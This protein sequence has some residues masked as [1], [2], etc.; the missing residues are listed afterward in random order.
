[1]SKFNFEKYKRGI[2]TIEVQTMTPEKFINLLWKN[3]V[4]IS[5][6]RRIDITTL[7]LD[8]NLRYYET[9]NSIAKRTNTKLKIIKRRGL[10]FFIIKNRRRKTL[11]L[12]ILIFISIIYYLST[13]I[14]NINITTE[15]NVTPYEIRNQLKDL[16]IAPALRKKK[17]NVYDLEEKLIKNNSDIMWVKA[18]IEGVKLNISI[19]ERQ[20]P[21]NVISD[22]S[23]CHIV[24]K[25]D[26]EIIRVYSSA[27]TAI[28]K[29][30]DIV[31][32]GDILVKGEQGKEEATYPV[33]ASAEVIARTFYEEKKQVPIEYVS[34]DRTGKEDK[35]VYIELFG[36]KIY[37]KKAKN[38]F[39]MYDKISIDDSF[40][41][42]EVYFEVQEK[43]KK[44]NTEEVK[45]KIADELF[46]NI[47]AKLDKS[48]KIVDKIVDAKKENDKYE[49]RVM[50]V[51]EENI[52][53]PQVFEPEIN[54]KEDKK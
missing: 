42:K 9:I 20:E 7:Q 52:A 2:I 43:K 30:G 38:N 37:L 17:I 15:N 19:S 29:S 1:M 21:P 14:W 22:N 28:V 36:K 45:E 10:S 48:V 41:K 47:I 31:K 33:H 11:T 49:V 3:G 27:G 23:P 46:S 8:A 32:K 6:V 26:G 35:N 13:F 25:K 12:G 53:E 39:E 44:I 54:E 50:L 16:G 34:R 4:N 18:R 24:A 40:I 51:V 5:N